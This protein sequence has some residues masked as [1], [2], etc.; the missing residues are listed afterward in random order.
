M[1]TVLQLHKLKGIQTSAE[2]GANSLPFKDQ[3]RFV[4]RSGT[5]A[6]DEGK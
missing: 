4:P 1:H 2:E 3:L 5:G 6:D